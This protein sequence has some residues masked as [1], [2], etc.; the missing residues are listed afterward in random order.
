MGNKL[1]TRPSF[2]EAIILNY[3]YNIYSNTHVL[4]LQKIMIYETTFFSK[5][6][7]LTEMQM[8]KIDTGDSD[9]TL[10]YTNFMDLY[11]HATQ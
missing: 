11:M 8:K 5:M 9:L 6:H 10:V 2:Y 7:F 3:V 1:S 4:I